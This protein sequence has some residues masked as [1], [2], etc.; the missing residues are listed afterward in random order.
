[1]SFLRIG[2]ARGSIGRVVPFWFFFRAAF[3]FSFVIYADANPKP[4]TCIGVGALQIP[5]PPPPP[6]SPILRCTVYHIPPKAPEV[7]DLAL[8]REDRA[9]VLLLLPASL[10]QDAQSA[11]KCSYEP[12][13]EERGP[14]PRFLLHPE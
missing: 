12:S 2:C 10:Q 11:S 14:P 3:L 5:L 13:R 1:M 8:K 9:F 6:P 7:N 4:P